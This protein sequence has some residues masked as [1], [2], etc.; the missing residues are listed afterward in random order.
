MDRHKVGHNYY[1]RSAPNGIYLGEPIPEQ[2]EP[3]CDRCQ[4][5][6]Q[7]GKQYADFNVLR[8]HDHV[9]GQVKEDIQQLFCIFGQEE[10]TTGHFGHAAQG[11][12]VQQE[13]APKAT[14]PATA[15]STATESTPATKNIAAQLFS[16]ADDVARILG[17][18]ANGRLK[19]KIKYTFKAC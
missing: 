17:T 2:R 1:R 15:K 5:C 11:W 13:I 16:G 8:L 3:Y 4:Q 18:K 14:T 6:A 12:L 7:G 19:Q 10:L 9:V